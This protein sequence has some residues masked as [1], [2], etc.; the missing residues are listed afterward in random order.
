MYVFRTNTGERC[1]VSDA[2]TRQRR[3]FLRRPVARSTFMPIISRADDVH[4]VYIMA[5]APRASTIII[6]PDHHY[7]AAAALFQTRATS[8][9]DVN[10]H[11]S[12]TTNET[13]L[14][15]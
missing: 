14:S 9:F 6:V 15:K 13:D 8:R 10:R 4:S 1:I 3:K 7:T 5:F 11:R 12:T 2:L